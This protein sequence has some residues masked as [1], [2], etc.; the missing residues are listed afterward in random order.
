MIETIN[1]S[2]I[3]NRRIIV[4]FRYQ[5]LP[6]L[7]D[8]KGQLI[9]KLVDAGVIENST[10]EFGPAEVKIADSFDQQISRKTL[11]IDLNRLTFI[12][13]EILSNQN[14]L[15][16]LH[17]VYSIVKEII[18]QEHI[19]ISRI[20]CRIQGTYRCGTSNFKKVLSGFIK[21]F[22]QKYLLED[23]I[24]TDL[25]FQ[26]VYEN[27]MYQIGPVNKNDSFTK[28][29]FQHKSLNDEVGFAIDTDNYT[30]IEK[31]KKDQVGESKLVDVLNASLSVEKLLFEKLNAIQF[32]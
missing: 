27:G 4:E 14:Y 22:P 28:R 12:D 10:W 5:S 23:F 21:E 1:E 11:F 20:G 31:G 32:E 9:K 13:S 16:T 26:L 19:K 30:A 7:T 18:G 24:A 6:H 15:D 25:R 29:V 3:W 8:V 2:S 17:K